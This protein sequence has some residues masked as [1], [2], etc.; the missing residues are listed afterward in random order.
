M[1]GGSVASVP[2]APPQW[3]SGPVQ[4]G[5]GS[6]L[7]AALMLIAVVL[8]QGW[9]FCLGVLA[10]PQG[11]GMRHRFYRSAAELVGAAWEHS[12][13][14]RTVFF[15]CAVYLT[16]ANRTA[17][18]VACLRAFWLDLDCG[19]GKPYTTQKAA[20]LA[21]D[22]FCKAVGLPLPIIVSSGYGLHVYWPM[23]ADITPQEWRT[24]ALLLKAAASYHGLHADPS[25]TS[26]AASVLRLPG[27]DNLKGEPRRVRVLYWSAPTPLES[28]R[29]AL[30]SNCGDADALGRMPAET[31]AAVAG[32]TDLTAGVTSDWFS[33]LTPV[34]KDACLTYMLDALDG[35]ADASH[36]EWIKY[37]AAC[38]R[39][40]AP[41]ARDICRHWSQRSP[42]KY[43][44]AVFD[45]KFDS[46]GD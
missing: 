38:A 44:P 7:A 24:V 41:H 20:V 18:N 19:E 35:V 37:V 5:D 2:A 40:G 27:T 32:N 14:G 22:A 31:V 16:E 29:A 9:L 23:D 34:Q 26:D 15:A 28:F 42:R 1:A 46:F 8:P 17:N 21:V 12:V 10:A 13:A 36:D 6:D 39:S 3:L 45:A 25:R 4:R 33:W 43:D 11:G 30:A